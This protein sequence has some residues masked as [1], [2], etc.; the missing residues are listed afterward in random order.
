M[1]GNAEMWGKMGFQRTF[2]PKNPSTTTVVLLYYHG[3]TRY[4]P[5][6]FPLFPFQMLFLPDKSGFIFYL[7]FY[8]FLFI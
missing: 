1:L 2:T 8:F 5:V 4:F 3:K 7:C 6:I